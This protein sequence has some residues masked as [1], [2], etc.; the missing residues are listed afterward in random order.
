M[1]VVTKK[2]SGSGKLKSGAGA[3]GRKEGKRR[4][5]SGLGGLMLN[6]NLFL[7]TLFLHLYRLSFT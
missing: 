7:V 2:S 1:V 6:G 5:K 3:E 4:R